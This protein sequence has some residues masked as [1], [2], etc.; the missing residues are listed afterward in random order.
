MLLNENAFKVLAEFCSDYSKRIYGGQVAKKLKMNQKTVA[1]V[2]NALEK[3]NIIKYST[4]G[5]NKYYFL[6]KLNPQISDTL[7]ILEL[8]RK[9]NF[10]A[11]YSKFRELFIALEK[12]A[13]GILIIFGSYANFTSNEK[14]D[15]DILILGKIGEVKDLEEKYGLK[16]N[17]VRSNKDKFNKEDVF[18][19]EVIKNHIILKGVEEFIDLTWQ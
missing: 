16:I 13:S 17:I 10:V 9:N 7:K 11:K 6:N 12:K 14:S 8:G 15:L 4:E 2:L 1:N 18:I 5:K 19:K 3:Q